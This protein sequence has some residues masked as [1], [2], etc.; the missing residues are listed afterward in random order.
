MLATKSNSY[1]SQKMESGI[2]SV[3]CPLIYD[4][5]TGRVGLLII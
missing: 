1:T 2:S 3:E 5:I 4:G